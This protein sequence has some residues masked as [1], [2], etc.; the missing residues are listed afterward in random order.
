MFRYVD[1]AHDAARLAY[2]DRLA[3]ALARDAVRR[4]IA[5]AAAV[6][7]ARRTPRLRSRPGGPRAAR[8]FRARQRLASLPR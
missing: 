8:A 5:E 4:A 7:D 6:K 1:V 2:E 3:K